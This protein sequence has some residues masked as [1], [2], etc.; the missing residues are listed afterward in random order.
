MS[1][2]ILDTET[3]GVHEPQPFQIAYTHPIEQ[4]L[5]VEL[6]RVE[7]SQVWYRPTK[8]I[9][10]GAMATCHVIDEDLTGFPP[11]PGRW[12]PRFPGVEYLIGHNVDFDWE[13]IG[14]PNVRRICTLALVRRHWPLLDSHRLAALIYHLKPHREARNLVKNAHSASTDLQLT[15]VV[16]HALIDW[17]TPFNWEHLWGLSESA[18]VPTH[19]TFGKYGPQNGEKQG[20]LIAEI[21]REDKSYIGW[22]LSGKCDIVNKDEYLQRALRGE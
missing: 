9:E 19:F 4:P 3:T 13:A 8:A 22:C 1:A 15:A 20:R 6:E 2:I 7:C 12:E 10:L 17:L 18:R 14:R 16:L 11:W 5:H 21:R